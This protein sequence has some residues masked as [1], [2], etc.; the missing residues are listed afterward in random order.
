MTSAW[1]PFLRFL[2]RRRVTEEELRPF[3][4]GILRRLA[5]DRAPEERMHESTTSALLLVDFAFDETL[6]ALKSKGQVARAHT[7]HCGTR[8][9]IGLRRYTGPL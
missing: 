5:L 8:R 3:L 6:R 2:Q 4:I 9:G 7:A 1:L